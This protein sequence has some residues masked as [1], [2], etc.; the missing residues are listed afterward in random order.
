MAGAGEGEGLAG[1]FVH[2][3]E[4]NRPAAC[5]DPD[6]RL[7][8]AAISYRELLALDRE[9]LCTQKGLH[10]ARVVLR[11]R[12]N[13]LV[14]PLL[15]E[16]ADIGS[17]YAPGLGMGGR[18]ACCGQERRNYEIPHSVLSCWLCRQVSTGPFSETTGCQMHALALS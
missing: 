18:D 3:P 15:R 4:Q 16:A 17:T 6:L 9:A 1:R 11:R 2:G 10:V 7:E 5:I 12:R 8:K 14:Q 13:E